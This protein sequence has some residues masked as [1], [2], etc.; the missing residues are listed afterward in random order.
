[1][2]KPK[3][4]FN[5]ESKISK[6]GEQLIF[7]NLNYGYKE[8][9]IST[10]KQKYIPMRI[11]TQWSIK[12]E[13][14]IGLPTYRAN[15]KYVSKFGKDLNSV[16]NKIETTSY[17]Q[18]SFY[19]NEHNEIPEP[20]ILK[21]KVLEKLDRATKINTNVFVTDFITKLIE[22]RTNLPRSSKEFWSNTTKIGYNNTLNHINNYEEYK[23]IKLSFE[24]MTEELYWDF[25][26]TINEIY[27][28]K[29]GIPY[30][31]T[32]IA[33]ECK[34]LKAIFNCAI[35][36]NI[37]IGFNFS[38]KGLKVKPSKAKHETYLS[39]KQLKCIIKADVSHS[40]ELQR[41]KDYIIISSFTGLRIGD[42]I[43]LHEIKPEMISHKD[44]EFLGFTTKIRK[45]QENSSELIATLPI[46]NPVKKILKNYNNSFPQFTS[47]SNIRACIK[48]LLKY[49]KFEDN[50]VVSY[51]YY[52]SD[53]VETINKKQSTVFTPHDCRRTFITNLK[54]LGV[55]NDTIEPITHPKINYKSVLDSY[56]KSTLKDKALKLINDLKSKNSKI[57]SL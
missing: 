50:V 25:F 4:N 45:S 3:H 52:L 10:N 8:F 35:E 15:R 38:K 48:K 36:E 6:S 12:K 24:Q 29:N 34:N 20:K 53:G 49:L 28:N 44:V 18:L 26:K 5:L 51:D 40:I 54:Q 31:I 14:W 41:A 47:M 2:K 30:I 33:K 19:K 43:H 22:K 37:A 23:N 17:E 27:K 16:L 21:Q 39:Q 9:D 7:F 11:S 46:L 55:Q 56:D 1:M 57:F 32:T 42:M 13:F